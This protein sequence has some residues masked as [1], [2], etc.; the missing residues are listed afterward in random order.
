MFSSKAVRTGLRGLPNTSKLHQEYL[1]NRFAVQC[2]RHV[3]SQE[4]PKR[5]PP[6][7]VPRR[8][9]EAPKTHKR[10]ANALLFTVIAAMIYQMWEIKLAYADAPSAPADQVEVTFE[11]TKKKKSGMTKEDNR[12]MISSQHVQVRKSWENPGVHA[13]GS[14]TGK[15]AAPDSD[16]AY[17]KTPRKISFFDG[18]LLRDLKLD[19]M[20]GA[21][22]TESGD[23]L[24]WGKGYSEDES[25][26][27]A[28][29]KGKNLKQLAISRDR[30]L[31][32]SSSG[33]VYSLPM[34]K[35]DQEEGFKSSEG[36]WI[37]FWNS[38]RA[39]VSYR[40]IQPENLGWSEKVTSISGGLEHILLLTNRG[41]VFSAASGSEDYP[42]K[43]QLG[44]P[45]LNWFT[46]PEGRYDMCHEIITLKGFNIAKIAAGDFHSV[47]L[48]KEGRCFSF[49]D[50][51][52]G[53]LGFEWSAQTPVIDC[54]SLI[55]LQQLY[56]GTN[57]VP[58]VINISAG[59]LNSFFEIDA[60]RVPGVGEEPNTIRGL[61]WTYADVWAAG[62]G[63]KGSL[64]TGKWVHSQ[65]VPAKITGLS[66]LFEYD[67]IKNKM[68]PIRIAQMSVGAT[69]AAAVMDNVTY[70]DASDKSSENDTNWGADALLWGCNEYYQIGNGRRNN[71][72]SPVYIQPLDRDAEKD[73][74]RGKEQHRLHITPR[75]TVKL[76]GR[77]VSMEQRFE[78]GRS[79]TAVYSAV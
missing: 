1:I 61:G 5:P 22:I 70:L 2:R 11:K 77:K 78:C 53:Q 17:I 6:G 30:I 41:R 36:S 18:K 72:P 71:T 76:Q 62:H 63:V 54:P 31:A 21:A 69:H 73:A 68:I 33:A 29:L 52:S 8:P 55:P 42:A 14:N 15:V 10:A 67:E 75:H 26:P 48:D 60:K 44:I 25:Q 59:G 79:L 16:E 19:R 37:P 32:L 56:R 50:N 3:S 46:R 58:K 27:I 38:R 35:L 74:G 12:D 40:K 49:G 23:L 28:T 66:G 57:Q 7:T 39:D 47:A 45:G 65:G 24:Q 34:S 51:T 43:G 4:P 13:W 64:G 20:F 9:F